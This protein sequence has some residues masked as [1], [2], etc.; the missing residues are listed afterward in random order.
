MRMPT[1]AAAIAASL[2][3]ALRSFQRPAPFDTSHAPVPRR[4]PTLFGAT[5]GCG[6]REC[7]RRR[8]QIERGILR[9]S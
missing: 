2:S 8:R 9:I 4:S 3:A 6:A 7:A 5:P 1:L